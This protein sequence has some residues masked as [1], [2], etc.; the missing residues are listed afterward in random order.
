MIGTFLFVAFLW[1]I[2]GRR[3]RH[4]GGLG[5]WRNHVEHHLDNVD[6]GGWIDTYRGGARVARQRQGEALSARGP[7]EPPPPESPLDA[8][9][10][11][12]VADEITVEEY[13]QQLD[14]LLKKK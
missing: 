14:E 13:E 6:V 12:Y 7:A 3:R 9:Q 4:R 11:R 8:L 2:F 1:V 5:R 10:R